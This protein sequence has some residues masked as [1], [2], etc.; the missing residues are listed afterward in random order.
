MIA[1]AVYALSQGNPFGNVM[2]PF[3]IIGIL[4]AW[5]D[6]KILQGG[7]TKGKERIATHL[8]RMLGGLIATITAV[9]VVNV[10]ADS[11]LL[12]LAV[13]LAPTIILVPVIFIWAYKIH[14]GTKRKGMD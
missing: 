1:Y 10:Q 2:I 4:N 14:A 8:A 6:R 12:L 7:G 11:G 9:L 3:S 5:D 13:W